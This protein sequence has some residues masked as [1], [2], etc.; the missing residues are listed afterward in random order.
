M[1]KRLLIKYILWRHAKRC[2]KEG[3]KILYITGYTKEF[4]DIHC[5]YCNYRTVGSEDEIENIVMEQHA[6][7]R[8]I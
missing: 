3:H 2:A 4:I 7:S 5:W 8:G 1:I 6:K